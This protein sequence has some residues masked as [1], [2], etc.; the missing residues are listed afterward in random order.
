MGWNGRGPPPFRWAALAAQ[1]SVVRAVV[2]PRDGPTTPTANE[3]LFGNHP[4]GPV[5]SGRG[6]TKP[7][8]RPEPPGDERWSTDRA[9]AL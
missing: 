3:R 5:Q 2:V 1:P 6:S 8:E 7:A 9:V 4:L